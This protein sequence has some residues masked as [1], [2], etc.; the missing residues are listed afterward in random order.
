MEED[1]QIN[2]ARFLSA[3]TSAKDLESYLSRGRGFADSSDELVKSEC[4]AE[5]KRLSEVD[6]PWD[7]TRLGDLQSELSIRKIE[8]NSPELERY[9]KALSA[10]LFAVL[11]RVKPLE[12][13]KY[14]EETV[15]AYERHKKTPN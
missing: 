10:K 12:S 11:G 9:S 1:E 15:E 2:F 6:P 14:L 13:S 8:A 4:I 7:L 3:R 5:V